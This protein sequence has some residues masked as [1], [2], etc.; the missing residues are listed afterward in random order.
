LKG[1]A[2]GK[3]KY[4]ELITETIYDGKWI[5]G[6]FING[7]VTNS[8]YIFTGEFEK[9]IPKVGILKF[10]NKNVRYMGKFE[11]GQFHDTQATY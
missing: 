2:N 10:T 4:I 3:G 7:L 6:K 11:N 5:E 9:N 1:K 8:Q